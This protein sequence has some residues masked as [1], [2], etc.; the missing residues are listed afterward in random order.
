MSSSCRKKDTR[1]TERH[2]TLLMAALFIRREQRRDRPLGSGGLPWIA[3]SGGV[4]LF[5]QPSALMTRAVG[6]GGLEPPTDGL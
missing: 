5:V 4:R 3:E 1:A 6:R 2:G